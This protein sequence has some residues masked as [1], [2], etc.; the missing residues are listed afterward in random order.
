MTQPTPQRLHVEFDAAEPCP[1]AFEGDPSIVLYFASWAFS[2]SFGAQHELAQA[3][4]RLETAHK[5]ELR[6]LLRY[7]DRQIEDEADR[8]ELERMWQDPTPLAGCCRAVAAGIAAGDEQLDALLEGYGDL[9][10]R[11][12]ELATM[13]DWA[14]QQGARVRLSFDLGAPE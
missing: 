12:G 4:R 3:A 5:V 6:P 8:Q 2:L 10:P 11:L 14:A 13:C 9:A 7:A 1:I